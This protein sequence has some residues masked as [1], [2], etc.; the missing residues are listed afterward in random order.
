MVIKYYV[1]WRINLECIPFVQFNEVSAIGNVRW[2]VSLYSPDPPF[3]FGGGS[4]FETREK[5]VASL[6]LLLI[7]SHKMW[8]TEQGCL[9]NVHFVGSR[10]SVAS[11]PGLPHFFF[12]W[13]FGLCSVSYMEAEEW[14]KKKQEGLGSF[15]MWMTSSGGKVDVGREGP[16]CENNALDHLFECSIAF[17][18]SRCWHGQNY[19]SIDR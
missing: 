15:I 11:F 14:Q 10:R 3:L 13:F 7:A 4:G 5:V 18:D 2:E 16:N 19:S 1:Q 12:F 6:L 8:W 9:Y 17:L